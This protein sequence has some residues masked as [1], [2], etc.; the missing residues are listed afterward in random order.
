MKLTLVNFLFERLEADDLVGVFHQPQLVVT[1][2]EDLA[3]P[4]H[5]LGW[6]NTRCR[7][8][9]GGRRGNRGS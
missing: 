9:F 6:G 1:H 5:L 4:S 3:E 8:G 7:K 2:I